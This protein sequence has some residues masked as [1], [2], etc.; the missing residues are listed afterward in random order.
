MRDFLRGR[1]PLNPEEA[2]MIFFFIL[3]IIFTIITLLDGFNLS[4]IALGLFIVT[5]DAIIAPYLYYSM[6]FWDYRFNN[7][8]PRLDDLHIDILFSSAK[9]FISFTWQLF[10]IFHAY[11]AISLTAIRFYNIYFPYEQDELILK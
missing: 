6:C 4:K 11:K 8:I 10:I 7:S 1:G 5:I 9:G 2:F 3:S